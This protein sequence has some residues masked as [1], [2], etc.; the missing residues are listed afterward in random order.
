MRLITCLKH[1]QPKAEHTMAERIATRAIVLKGEQILLL[2]TRRYNDYSL[3]GGGVDAG[4][5][6]QD[7]LVRELGE[8]TGAQHVRVLSEFGMVDEY[9]PWYRNNID[10]MFMRSYCYLCQ[11]EGELG[12]PQLE[13]HEQANGMQVRWVNIHAAIAH[14]KAVMA[15]EAAT[16]GLSIVRETLLLETIAAECLTGCIA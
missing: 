2:Y 12:T 6:L 8:E 3:P 4:E 13:D 16:T 11:L 15:S 9:R 7:A 14:N 5:T 10:V 1:I